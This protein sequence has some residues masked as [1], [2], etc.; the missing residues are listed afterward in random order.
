VGKETPLQQQRQASR[1]RRQTASQRKAQAQTLNIGIFAIDPG[2]ATGLAW[3]IVDPVVDIGDS[4]RGRMNAGSATVKGDAREQIREITSIWQ[5]FYRST[6]QFGC[7]PPENVW[8]VCEDFIY[9]SD[10]QYGGEDSKISTALIWGIEGYRMGQADEFMKRRGKKRLVMRDMIL[11]APGLASGFANNTR[12]RD[13]GCWVVGRDHERSAYR[14]L[15]LFLK[16]YQQQHG[17]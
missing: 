6:V 12:L 3:A 8:L 1:S 15:A 11:Q 7:L 16:R 10:N 9:R 5:S 13:W 4:L 14:H 2:G 17:F